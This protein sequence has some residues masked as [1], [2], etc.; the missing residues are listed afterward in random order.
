MGVE[1]AHELTNA[2]YA[3]EH[4][5]A[6]FHGRDVFTRGRPPREGPRPRRARARRRAGSLIRLELPQPEISERRIRATCLYVDRFGNMQLN[7]TRAD[8][9]QCGV[10]PG[11]PGRGRA[12]RRPLLRGRGPHVRRRARGRDHPVRGRVREHR[13]R[14]LGRQRGA[15]VQRE[16]GSRAA[17][18]AGP[19]SIGQAWAGGS[20]R[21]A[22]NQV[23]RDVPGCGSSS[24]ARCAGCS[25]RSR[26]SGT[27]GEP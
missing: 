22:T 26:P 11:R 3:L 5:S 1:A 4:V 12:L 21:V 10:E 24:A 16:P 15:D 14:D 25:T 13:A 23:V 27:R 2:E 17:H 6:T 7:L 9:D 19:M 20:P 18:P 8:L